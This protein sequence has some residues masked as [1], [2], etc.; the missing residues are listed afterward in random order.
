[1]H[2][3]CPLHDKYR[4]VNKCRPAGQLLNLINHYK[5]NTERYIRHY[6]SLSTKG[7]PVSRK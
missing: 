7:L 1:M 5:T 3:V 2:F 4:T 6:P